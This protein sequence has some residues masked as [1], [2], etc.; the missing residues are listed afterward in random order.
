[1]KT[2]MECSID[3]VEV[4]EVWFEF[5][6]LNLTQHMRRGANVNEQWFRFVLSDSCQNLDHIKNDL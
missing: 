3:P 2:L 4:V 1:M 6:S 5:D